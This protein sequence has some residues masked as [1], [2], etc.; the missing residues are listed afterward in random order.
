MG[1]A[2]GDGLA[3]G[4]GAGEAARVGLAADGECRVGLGEEHAVGGADPR[5][6]LLIG[7]AQLDRH[8][9]GQ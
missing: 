8:E 2:A 9:A 7:F 1:S 3:L 4:V 6:L 5:Q